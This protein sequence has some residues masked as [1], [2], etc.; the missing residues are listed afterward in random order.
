MTQRDREGEFLSERLPP[1]NHRAVQTV[2]P[3]PKCT[4]SFLT[5]FLT[6][7]LRLF[8]IA[9]ETLYS[10]CQIHEDQGYGVEFCYPIAVRA[11]LYSVNYTQLILLN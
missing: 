7:H 5:Y 9:I 4:T 8:R 11:S 10:F 1:S 3:I 6:N 2:H